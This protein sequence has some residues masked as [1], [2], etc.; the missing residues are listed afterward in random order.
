MARVSSYKINLDLESSDETKKTIVSFEKSLDRISKSAKEAGKQ[1]GADL[2]KSLK[3]AQ[4]EA[5]RLAK[6]VD[7]VA[8]GGEDAEEAIAAYGKAAGKAISELEKQNAKMLYST[9][10]QG[11]VERERLATLREEYKELSKDNTKKKEAKSILKEIKSIEKNVVDLSD[12]ELKDAIKINRQTR[13]TLKLAQVN[14]K[15][16]KLEVKQ[17]KSLKQLFKDDISL[18]KDKIKKQWEF[19]K[20]LKST[21]KQYNLIK[22]AAK[23]IGKGAVKGV[24]GAGKLAVKG[25]GVAGMAAG[26][27]GGMAISGAEEQVT[28]EQEARRIKGSMSTQE[29][30][31]LLSDVYIRTGGDYA[32]IVNAI[33]RVQSVLGSSLDKEKLKEA[34]VAEMQFPGAAAM[35]MQQTDGKSGATDFTVYANRMKA[36]QGQTGASIEQIQAAT[37]K[38]S[39]MSQ[40][41]FSNSAMTD[42]QSVYLAL[43]NSGG[44]GSEDELNKAFDAFA[45]QQSES[46]QDVFEFAKNFN[47]AKYST[48]DQNKAQAVNALANVDWGG[49]SEKARSV[50]TED[51]RS[52]SERTAEKMR[53]LQQKL[54]ELQIR[55]LET[56]EPLLSKIMKLFEG[57]DGKKIMDGLVS[58][59][60]V[61]G[62]VIVPVF[63]VL[64][65]FMDKIKPVTDALT[66]GI[67]KLA[68]WLGAKFDDEGNSETFDEK[69][70]RQSEDFNRRQREGGYSGHAEA[71]GGIVTMPS[72]CGEAGA[73]MVVPLSHERSA[74]AGNLIQNYNQNFSMNGNETTALSLARAVKSRS[75]SNAMSNAQFLFSRGGL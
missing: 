9:T 3:E 23:G 57:E 21:E 2:T 15:N 74:R 20:S 11:K 48:G 7:K 71:N 19:V 18:I 75:F 10:E 69:I 54:S 66:S 32:E 37:E 51:K 33:G 27:L 70:Q 64:K 53:G 8:E 6:E 47:W 72:L 28:K 26:M 12:D 73:E 31:K 42:M 43:Q 30:Q 29:K 59:V 5:E 49:L 45:K 17:E 68:E 52:V 58:L 4:S 50:S 41:R 13:A 39:N 63:K 36:V 60:E 40:G 1:T 24:A 65:W 35:F 34:A 56:L 16:K 44:Y 38:I 62:S 61:A 67:K 55:I 22:K 14:A 46:G 25:A